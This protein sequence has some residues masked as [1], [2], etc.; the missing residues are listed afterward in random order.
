VTSLA[1]TLAPALD[2]ALL[3][4]QLGM[5]LDPWQADAMRSIH[6]RELWNCSRQVG[7]S[8]TAALLALWVAVYRAPAL[9]VLAS[10]TLHQSAELLLKV[11]AP[12]HA[13]EPPVPA[14]SETQHRLTLTNGSRIVA[15][16]GD[17][18]SVRGLSSPAMILVDEASRVDDAL[19]VALSPML[20]ASPGGRLV[21]LSSPAGKRGAFWRFWSAD[22]PLWRRVRVPAVDC[23]RI[24]PRFLE[25]ERAT[26]SDTMYRQEYLCSFEENDASVFAVDAVSEALTDTIDPLDVP[27]LRRWR[28]A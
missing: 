5:D 4:P 26:M 15:V 9:V 1:R 10:P 12:W 14:E 20:A 2:P 24:S 16:S 3:G 7:K 21:M 13:L 18:T 23:P 25:Q 17:E 27:A 8:T 11:T 6:P 19:V 22:D 28:S